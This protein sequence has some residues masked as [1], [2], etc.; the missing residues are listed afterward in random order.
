M[1]AVERLPEASGAVVTHMRWAARAALCLFI[2]ALAGGVAGPEPIAARQG[3]PDSVPPIPGV[4]VDVSVKRYHVDAAT[5][6]EVASVLNGMRLEGPAG[7]RSQGLTQYRIVPEWRAAASN[8]RCRVEGLRVRAVIQ[9]TLPEWPRGRHRP[10]TERENWDRTEATIRRHEVHHR[11]LVIAA[12]RDLRA[13]LLDVQPTACSNLRQVVAGI[14]ALA[15]E[16]LDEAHAD[17]DRRDRGGASGQ[18]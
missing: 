18:R 15:E 1:G 6:A 3:R 2:A 11:D 10:L 4:E 9:I 12:A 16:S 17:F 13:A 7:P 8:G 5:F 14:L